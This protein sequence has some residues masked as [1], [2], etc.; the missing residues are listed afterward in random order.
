MY[1]AEINYDIHDW[2]ILAVDAVLKQWR[3]YFKGAHHQIQMYPEQ[4]NLE[5]FSS[6]N[7]FNRRQA[8]WVN[9]LVGWY[10]QILYQPGSGNGHPDAQSMHSEYHPKQEGTSIEENNN[11]MVHHVLRPDQPKSGEGYDIWTLAATTVCTPITVESL[12]SQGEPNILLS[13]ILKA[14][15]MLNFVIHMYQD[16]IMSGRDEYHCLVAYDTVSARR[17]DADVTLE[18]EVLGYKRRLCVPDSMDL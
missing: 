13:Q 10:F 15:A 14:T 18:D 12:Q 9:E 5:Y 8:R 2:E 3:P 16:V 4:T 6:L 7:I 11:Q 1:K 17:E